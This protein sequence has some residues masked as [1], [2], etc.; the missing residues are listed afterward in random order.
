MACSKEM[1]FSSAHDKSSTEFSLLDPV[2]MQSFVPLSETALK[3]AT[4]IHGVLEFCTKANLHIFFLEFS[5]ISQ[6]LKER[7]L[8]QIL[9]GVLPCHL[10]ICTCISKWFAT[11][12]AHSGMNMNWE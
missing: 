10:A 12:M 2:L 6:S 7:G 11:Q 5:A 9:K 3:N 1:D 8:K 4:N